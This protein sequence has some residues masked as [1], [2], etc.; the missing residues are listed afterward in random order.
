[1][2]TWRQSWRCPHWLPGL[3]LALVLLALP[4]G[5]TTAEGTRVTGLEV[6]VRPGPPLA[7]WLS[8]APGEWDEIRVE[9]SVR[10]ERGLATGWTVVI[11]APQSTPSCL[12]HLTL[13]PR[14]VRALA[15]NPHLIGIATH[16]VDAQGAT[17]SRLLE[18]RPGHGDGVYALAL[19]VRAVCPHT[20]QVTVYGGAP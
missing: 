8:L 17:A 10:D 13:V 3:A 6:T 19:G 20:L 12:H 15:G 1:M 2:P 16:T 5:V 18:A 14:S 11:S 4:P 9:V 7:A